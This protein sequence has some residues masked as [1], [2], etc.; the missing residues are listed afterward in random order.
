M[1]PTNGD[2]L[3]QIHKQPL[4]KFI[5]IEFSLADAIEIAA[6]LTNKG[7]PQLNTLR[8]LLIVELDRLAAE[9]QER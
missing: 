5:T 9:N 6:L 8:S 1:V 2:T 7:H 4:L 3:M